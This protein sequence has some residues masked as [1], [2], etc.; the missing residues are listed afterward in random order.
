MKKL[1]DV[2]YFYAGTGFPTQYQGKKDGVY[3]FYKVGDISKNVLKGNVYLKECDNFIDKDIV[4]KIRGTIIP[5]NTIVFAKI[6]EAL[7]LNRRAITITD[8]LVDNNAM[9]IK[10]NENQINLHYFFYYMCQLDLQK[11]AEST[12][13]PSV[14]KSKLL[15][16]EINFPPLEE[17][18]RIASVLDKVSGLI[19]KRRRQMDRLDELVKSEF[20]E[21][22]GDPVRNPFGW[23]KRKLVDI[24]TK[25]T[26]GT[27]FSPES[28]PDGEYKYITAKNIKED[29]FDFTNLTYVTKDVH[30]A[31]YARC[32]PEL[33]DVLYI[34]DGVTTGIAMTN[35]LNEPFTMLSSVALLKQNRKLILGEFLCSV[36]NDSEMYRNIRS[37]MGG[38]AITRLTI[39]KLK[40]IMIILPPLKLQ[41]Q[42]V[43]IKKQADKS[44]DEIKKSLEKL[45]TL[46]KALMQKYFG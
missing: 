10:P 13:V 8:C 34:K 4:D 35:S 24:C 5:P 23:E 44:K 45:E 43:F 20:I 16:I 2:C 21:M 30:D 22:F 32:N 1:K 3:P 26:D 42:F 9:G 33:G 25:L 38:A 15:E 29:G 6:G 28:F 14:R 46:K 12:A 11:Y 19:D 7:R 37:N 17:Q 36:L 18:R 40:E 41:Q 31:I 39:K 27:H